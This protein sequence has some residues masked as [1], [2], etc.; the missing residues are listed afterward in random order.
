MQQTAANFPGWTRP[1][2]HAGTNQLPD[3]TEGRDKAPGGLVSRTVEAVFI[4]Q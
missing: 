1:A 4:V 2:C 3:I